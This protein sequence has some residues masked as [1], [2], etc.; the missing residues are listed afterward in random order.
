MDIVI[1]NYKVQSEN[2][3]DITVYS[4]LIFFFMVS[5][6]TLCGLL[7]TIRTAW[8]YQ[9]EVIRISKSKNRQQNGRK[10]TNKRT[11]K[12]KDRVT[13]TPLKS[14]TGLHKPHLN[15]HLNLT[16]IGA[17]QYRGGLRCSGG[18]SSSWPTNIYM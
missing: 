4:L 9:M 11:N 12:T 16:K 8:I 5:P 10:K 13:R 15:W 2:T 17:T 3:L 18:V 7:S 6:P 1:N 14:W